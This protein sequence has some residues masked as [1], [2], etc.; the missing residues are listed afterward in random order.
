M[1]DESQEQWSRAR[2]LRVCGGCGN[3]IAPGEPMFESVAAWGA[4]VT[5]TRCEECRGP[6]PELPALEPPR[7][8]FF[9]TAR[10][11]FARITGHNEKHNEGDR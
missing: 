4:R 2:A 1:T 3:L 11:T 8:G 7:Q 10:L 5:I 6:A 9:N